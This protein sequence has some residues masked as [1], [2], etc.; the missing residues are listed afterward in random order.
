MTSLESQLIQS[1]I[2]EINN[3]NYDLDP[4]GPNAFGPSYDLHDFLEV[5]S[6]ELNRQDLIKYIQNH[7]KLISSDTHNGEKLF[8]WHIDCEQ[9]LQYPCEGLVLD[10]TYNEKIKS[11][12]NMNLNYME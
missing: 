1:V 8:V 2:K 6:H 12:T 5:R 4:F 7:L 3:L 9:Y 11:I 10:V